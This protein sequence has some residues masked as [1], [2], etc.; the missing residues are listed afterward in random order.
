MP[1]LF[2][3]SMIES[4]N[5]RTAVT[6][7]FGGSGIAPVVVTTSK[8]QKNRHSKLILGGEEQEEEEEEEEELCMVVVTGEYYAELIMI[9]LTDVELG[10]GERG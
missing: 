4:P 2:P 5:P 1:L 7:T 10:L 6:V 3:G 8:R 9:F